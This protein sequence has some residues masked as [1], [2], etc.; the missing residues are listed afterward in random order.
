MKL[1]H[2]EIEIDGDMGTNMGRGYFKVKGIV[3]ARNIMGA[4][5]KIYEFYTD[6][7][8]TIYSIKVHEDENEPQEIS[9]EQI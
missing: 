5:N 9:C 7:E 6:V 2:Y 8:N 4:M 3:V 1:F